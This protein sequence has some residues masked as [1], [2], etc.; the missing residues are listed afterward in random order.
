MSITKRLSQGYPY[1]AEFS[2]AELTSSVLRCAKKY[3]LRSRIPLRQFYFMDISD[4]SLRTGMKKNFLD[5][6]PVLIMTKPRPQ[7]AAILLLLQMMNPQPQN[8]NPM[9]GPL[10]AIF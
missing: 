8:Q 5:G 10:K 3:R 6:E 7:Q 4:R 9:Y 2:F 1:L